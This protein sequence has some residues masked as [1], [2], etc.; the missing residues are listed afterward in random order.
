M[1]MQLLL[2]VPWDEGRGGVVN[3]AENLAKYL[4]TLGHGVLFFHPGQTVVLK[5]RT[6]KRGF[7]GVQLRI[8][9]PFAQPRPIVSALAFP[10]LFPIMLIQ[11]IWFLRR[12]NIH[13][14][15]LHFPIDNFFYFAICRHLLSIRLVTSVHGSDAFPN[16][17]PRERY[18]RAFRY[19]IRSSDL[20]VLPSDTYRKKF[21]DVFPCAR[22]KTVFIHNGINPIDFVLPDN[23]QRIGERNRYI[24]CIAAMT[25]WKGIDVLLNASKPL[26]MGDPSLTLVLVGEGP[27]RTELEQLAST[28]GICKQTRFLG[29]KE[30]SEIAK[31]LNG[32]EI[33]VL[34]SRAESFGIVVI[35][36]LACRKPVVATAVGGIPEIIEDKKT[37]IL[38]EPDDA[39]ALADALRSLLTNS[40]LKTT[41]AENGYRRV[42]ERFCFDRT[43]AAY[44][45]AYASL[46]NVQ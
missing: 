38:V 22:H 17:K 30:P 27:L 2:V 34:P 9:F 7:P 3:V 13:V 5:R 36:A 35:E 44:E 41:L 19:M 23:K 12:H 14:V 28:I 11:L 46:W 15:N 42:M 31:L 37:G 33:F 43:G 4:H 40:C 1:K 10:V 39:A 32:C 26:L 18:S 29:S 20:I 16:G 8:G 45:N 25:E 24:L 6:T 21:L